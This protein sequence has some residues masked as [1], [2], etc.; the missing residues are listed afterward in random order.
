MRTADKSAVNYPDIAGCYNVAYGSW[1]EQSKHPF[2]PPSL[3][4]STI[5]DSVY[6]GAGLML[7]VFR[8]STNEGSGTGAFAL[9]YL[10]SNRS[11][12][13]AIEGQSRIAGYKARLVPVIGGLEGR[14]RF[15]GDL[16]PAEDETS[17]RLNRIE[18]QSER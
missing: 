5:P 1:R 2:M 6:A 12:S 17:I 8:V 11:D 10:P 15:V 16:P 3:E 13:V 14:V 4:L 7:R 18:C 9:W